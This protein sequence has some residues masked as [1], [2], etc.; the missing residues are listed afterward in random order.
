MAWSQ[1]QDEPSGEIEELYAELHEQLRHIVG[2][3]VRAPEALI[4]DACAT[5]WAR[6]LRRPGRL[7]RGPA[8][9]WLI[10]TATREALRQI[11]RHNREV[12]LDVLAQ[13]GLR[14]RTAPDPGDVVALRARLD[15]VGALSPR[16]Q[17]LIWLQG[18]GYSYVEMADET[19]ATTRTVERQL[20]R[21]KA[22][23]RL[24]SSPSGS[25]GSALP[26]GPPRPSGRSGRGPNPSP[27]Q[28]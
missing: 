22:R 2:F 7:P 14:F 12:P 8:M 1:R 9:A 3:N 11:R 21:A 6:L 23:L 18:L 16:Q 24:I 20:L 27:D 28:V 19:G 25:S 17:R 26:S 15:E 10:T 5:A 4:E 13:A